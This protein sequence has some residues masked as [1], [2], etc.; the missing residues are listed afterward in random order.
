MAS[1]ERERSPKE[2]HVAIRNDENDGEAFFLDLTAISL[3]PVQCPGSVSN[4]SLI[5]IGEAVKDDRSDTIMTC[6]AFK[7]DWKA[8]GL[9]HWKMRVSPW[10]C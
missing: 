1:S 7:D 9:T 4:G 3:G 10:P 2:A 5:T 8:S 6:V